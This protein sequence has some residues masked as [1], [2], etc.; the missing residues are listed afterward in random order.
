MYALLGAL[1]WGSFWTSLVVSRPATLSVPSPTVL[2]TASSNET[3][4][5]LA[6][7]RGPADLNVITRFG[8]RPLRPS[9]CYMSSIRLLA[10]R[11]AQPNPMRGRLNG[12]FQW[13]SSHFT[14][15]GI[16]IALDTEAAGQYL[17]KNILLWA[18]A[19]ILHEMTQESRFLESESRLVWRGDCVSSLSFRLTNPSQLHLGNRT[20]SLIDSGTS[21]YTAIAVGLARTGEYTSIP[22]SPLLE[23]DVL[24][25]TI[26]ALIQLASY[27]EVPSQSFLGG[28]PAYGAFITWTN[29]WSPM[30]RQSLDKPLLLL[31]MVDSA[32]HAISRNDFNAMIAVVYEEGREIATGG[33]FPLPASQRL[34]SKSV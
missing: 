25:S 2:D 30:P 27:R 21:N 7:P 24:M 31:C 19:R 8:I 12:D 29:R 17:P 33:Y 15:S 18:M 22:S 11:A 3:H 28:F 6:D 20:A 32:A 13:E 23:K 16:Q 34:R 14:D 26:G 9:V 1:F 5:L 4:P 10:F